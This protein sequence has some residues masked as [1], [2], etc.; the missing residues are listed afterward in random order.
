MRVSRIRRARTSDAEAVAALIRPFSAKNIMLE[1]APDYVLEHINHY[2]V[3]E[4]GKGTIAG[5]VF[6][7]PYSSILAE[8]RSLAVSP[9]FQ[10]HGVGRKLVQHILKEAR[11]MGIRKVFALT[12]VPDFFRS[13]GFIDEVKEE[14]FP[15][16]IWSDCSSC[17]KKD[18]CDEVTLSVTLAS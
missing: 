4:A 16:K 13:L 9:E 8:V 5:V 14:S 7:R 18:A 10:G 6:L 17:A 11:R 2:F 12:L 15:E 1:V 3:A